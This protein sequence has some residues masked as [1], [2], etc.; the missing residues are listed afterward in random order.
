MKT[1][2]LMFLNFKNFPCLKLLCF[3]HIVFYRGFK[4]PMFRLLFLFIF[5]ISLEAHECL[6]FVRSTARPEQQHEAHAKDPRH[7]FLE[8]Q[9]IQ[10]SSYGLVP[11]AMGLRDLIGT[12]RMN[13]EITKTLSDLAVKEFNARRHLPAF[14]IRTVIFRHSQPESFRQEA[15]GDRSQMDLVSQTLDSMKEAMTLVYRSYEGQ[16]PERSELIP[17][18]RAQ[19]PQEHDRVTHFIINRFIQPLTHIQILVSRSTNEKLHIN[20]SWTPE[21]LQGIG[22]RT[23]TEL[24]GEAG[25]FHVMSPNQKFFDRHKLIDPVTDLSREDLKFYQYLG[26][27]RALSWAFFDAGLDRLVIQVNKAV[28]RLLG[29][30]K[31]LPPD[32]LD[33]VEVDKTWDNNGNPKHVKEVIYSFDRKT[34]MYLNSYYSIWILRH[35]LKTFLEDPFLPERT[36]GY[37]RFMARDIIL[38]T[39]MDLIQVAQSPELIYNPNEVQTHKSMNGTLY[40]PYREL[41]HLVNDP[42]SKKVFALS[43]TEA[44]EILTRIEDTIEHL[45]LN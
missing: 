15:I 25:R 26:L 6:S 39:N 45:T 41:T 32:K 7:I 33:F 3:Y 34:M 14:D 19:E 8:E 36:F 17:I 28:E 2:Q 42:L 27:Q 20:E 40:L 44:Q 43:T 4:N 30:K 38:L 21:Q 10:V 13:P 18:A 31:I 29:L 35:W 9:E 11:V 5:P 23:D 1:I 16:G 37:F 22:R 24:V 12:E